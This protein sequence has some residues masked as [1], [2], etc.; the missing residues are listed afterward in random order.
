VPT[1]YGALKRGHPVNS[2]TL[3][4]IIVYQIGKGLKG[5]VVGSL[6]TIRETACGELPASQ[7]I[8]ETF[9]AVAFSRT[10]AVGTVA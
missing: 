9:T 10:G 7:V 3:N 5:P 2:S 6:Y 1:P 4:S 8:G